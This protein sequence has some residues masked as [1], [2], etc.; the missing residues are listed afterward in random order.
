LTS[1][2]KPAAIL[3]DAVILVILLAAGLEVPKLVVRDP[4]TAFAVVAA[5]LIAV[6]IAGFVSAARLAPGNRWLHLGAVAI[7]IWLAMNAYVA[8][9]DQLRP[10]DAIIIAI[11]VLIAAVIGGGLSHLVRRR[12]PAR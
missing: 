11:I 1:S 7:V 10:S 2:F 9:T 6:G 8:A 5:A 4:S 3:R 12:R